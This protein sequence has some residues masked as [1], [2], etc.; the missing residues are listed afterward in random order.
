MGN[1]QA[2]RGF[3]PG[4]RSRKIAKTILVSSLIFL[5]IVGSIGSWLPGIVNAF[6]GMFLSS[7]QS[8]TTCSPAIPN[9]TTTLTGS[10]SDCSPPTESLGTVTPNSVGASPLPDLSLPKTTLSTVANLPLSGV[11]NSSSQNLAIYTPQIRMRLLGG[12]TPHDELLG[13]G[14]SVL[15]H[16]LF[17]GVEADV[18]GLQVPLLPISSNFTITGT[19]ETGTFIL[20]RMQVT[21]GLYSGVLAVVYKATSDGPLAWDL[22]FTASSPGEYSIV[23]TWG[24]LTQTS[25][26]YPSIRQFSAHYPFG[27]YTFSWS[28]ISNSFNLTP[29]FTQRQFS[30]AID[31][32][33]VT[34][35]AKVNV[36]PSIVGSNGFENSGT[37]TVEQR[38]VFYDQKYGNWWV[39]Y[40][41][42]TKGVSYAYSHDGINWIAQK[43]MPS[44]WQSNSNPTV[45]VNGETAFLAAGQEI[46]T[47]YP[48]QSTTTTASLYYAYGTISST[49]ISWG[50][51]STQQYSETCA[52]YALCF[53]YVWLPSATWTSSGKLAFTYNA[54]WDADLGGSTPSF[55]NIY[56][57]YDTYDPIYLSTDA[58]NDGMA[59]SIAASDAYGSV[60][61]VYDT[62]TSSVSTKGLFGIWSFPKN[63][64]NVSV[65]LDC[66]PNQQD[67]LSSGIPWSF[68]LAADASFRLHLL[69]TAA[70]GGVTELAFNMKG[71][72]GHDC[73]YLSVEYNIKC[74]ENIFGGFVTYPSI[75]PDFSTSHLYAFAIYNYTSI[76]M[77]EYTGNWTQASSSFP[78]VGLSN[79]QELGSN[80]ASASMTNSSQIGL[81][82]ATGPIWFGSIP[83]QTVW[84][85][86]SSP[87]DPWNGEGIA[88]YGQYFQNLDESVSTSSGLLTIEQTDM[89]VTG[90]G[91]NLEFT[92]VYTEPYAFIKGVASVENDTWAPMGNGWQLNFPWMNN[93]KTP[94]DIH[95][96][97]GEGYAIPFE[98]WTGTNSIFD[99]HKGENFRLIRNSTATYLYT[100]SGTAYV[101]DPLSHALTKSV[102]PLGNAITF[103]YTGGQIS[104]LTD[105]IGRVFKFCYTSGLL[106]SIEQNSGTCRTGFVRR[107][108]YTY[109]GQELAS[110]ADPAGR[111]TNYTYG[112]GIS[113]VQNWIITRLTYP[114]GWYSNYTYV[115]FKTGSGAYTYRATKL[116]VAS[117]TAPVREFLYAYANGNGDQI[118]NSTVTSLDGASGTLQTISYTSY[119]F[120]FAGVSANVSDAYH[121]FL[122]GTEQRFGVNGEIPREIILVSPTQGYTNYYRYD[123]W[124]NQIYSRR[125]INPSSNWYH[126]TFNAYYNDGLPPGFN[127]FQ[128]TFS[129]SN[130][131]ATDNPWQVYN[132]TWLVNNGSYNGTSPV[133]NPAH[134]EGMFAWTNFTSPSISMIA[135]VYITK[136]TGSSDQRVGLIGHYPGSGLR[137]WALVLHNS[138]SGMKLSLLDESVTWKVENPCTL[139]YNTWYK[140][141]FTLSGSQ[142][143]GS[144]TAPGV[145]CSVSGSFASTDITTATGFGLYAGG[146]AALFANV[147]VTD[148]APGITGTAFSNSFISNG[149]PISNIHDSLAG[150]AQLTGV[151]P[152]F[153]AGWNSARQ[154][155]GSG[156]TTQSLTICNLA[157]GCKAGDTIIVNYWQCCSSGQ[158]LSSVTDTEGNAYSHIV[159]AS[160]ANPNNVMADVWGALSI[161]ADT[162]SLTVTVTYPDT[163]HYRAIFIQQYRK[164]SGFG[165]THFT[166]QSSC[167]STSESLTNTRP[168]SLVAVAFD[169]GFMTGM[170]ETSGPAAVNDFTYTNSA[171]WGLFLWDSSIPNIGSNIWTWN[172]SGCNSG[173]QSVSIELQGQNPPQETYYGYVTSGGL[174]QTK[175]LYTLT[176]GPQWLTTART[177]DSFGNLAQVVD[178]RGNYTYYTYSN[179]Y[180]NAYLTN[181]TRGL[182]PGGTKITNLY[183]YNSTTGSMLSSVDPNGYNTTYKYDVLGR[184]TRVTYP[185]QDYTI[186]AYNDA[187]NY[188]NITNENSWKTKQIYDGLGRLTSTQK[189]LSGAVYS[190]STSTYNWMDKP[191]SNTDPLGNRYSYKY[192]AL[193][194]LN[195]TI[196]PD[197]NQTLVFYNDTASWVRY[198][199]EY[200]NFRCNIYDRLGRLVSVI[201]EADGKCQT[202]IVTNYYYDEIGDLVKVTNANLVST[203]Y[204]YDSVGRL[205]RTI[206]ADSTSELYSY[207]N[208]GNMASKTDRNGVQTT[209]AY[210]SLD[211]LS[212]ITYHGSTMTS[213]SY[214]YDRDS[215]LLQLQNQ[216]ATLGYTYDSRSRV[217][218][219]TYSV[220]GGLV[221]GPCGSGGGGG[222]SVA[223]GTLITT[224]NGT[225]IAV[226]NLRVGDRMLGY[227]TTTSQFTVS[228]VTSIR[229]VDTSNMLII[230]TAAGIP[231]RVDANPRQTLWVQNSTGG[232]GWTPVTAIHP[233]DSLFTVNGWVRVTGIEF[234]P[235][236]TH[237]MYDIIATAPYFADGYL[238]PFHKGPTGSTSTPS[239]IMLGG[240]SFTYSYNGETL[241]Q[242]TY[243]DWAVASYAYD[244]LGRV[245]SVSINNAG[246]VTTLAQFSY[247]Q[248]DQ[249][250]GIVYGNGIVAN[251]TYT[252]L[253]QTSKIDVKNGAAVL[254]ELRYSYNKTGT[255]ASVAG[256]ITNTSGVSVKLKDQYHYDALNRVLYANNTVGTMKPIIRYTYDS[257]GNRLT[258]SLN[259]V[260]TSYTYD[261]STNELKSAST[262]NG[263]SIGYSYYPNGNL[264]TSNVTVGST[265]NRWS[266]SWSVPGSRLSVTN[267]TLVEGYYA[268]D[269]LERMVEANEGSSTTFHSYT[270]TDTLS[271]QFTSGASNDYVYA[272]G[273]RI[274]RS[275]EYVSTFYYHTDALGSTRLTTDVSHNIVFSDSYQAYGQDNSS[276]GSETYKFTGKPASQTTGLYYEYQRWYDP[277]IGRFISED[278]FAAHLSDPQSLNPYVYSG[279]TPTTLT[280]PSGMSDSGGFLG[281]FDTY[282]SRPYLSWFNQN[283]L[284]P[285]LTFETGGNQAAVEAA[286]NQNAG[287]ENTLFDSG[288]VAGAVV[289]TAAIVAPFVVGTTA[290]EGLVTTGV[291]GCTIEEGACQAGADALAK[292]LVDLGSTSATTEDLVS[293]SRFWSTTERVGFDFGDSQIHHLLPRQFGAF[294]ERAG[295][296]N[297]DDYTVQ[298]DRGVHMVLHGR[299]GLYAESWNPAWRLFLLNNPNADSAQILYYLKTLLGGF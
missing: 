27:D 235:A 120:S 1:D 44:G 15:S 95:L 99:N 89:S 293:T 139:N 18:N 282:V 295:I 249:T 152:F 211:R 75:T 115:P 195:T 74:S 264:K 24:N 6:G 106:T 59:T 284:V 50:A 174:S 240:Y 246:V 169:I 263:P 78:V 93:T 187:A 273:L 97:N 238:D 48:S 159:L 73:Q 13:P 69:Y 175:R 127:V 131:T 36:D 297:I 270:G 114:T 52:A 171:G 119:S 163:S 262:T 56:L 192:D 105:T 280:D 2:I 118:S 88:P 116:Y 248:N 181:E 66:Y 29:S 237:V 109:N 85:P 243:N 180:S 288:V 202:G 158:S 101:F 164:V 247:T 241:S 206:Y 149:A 38:H 157:G 41:N 286:V 130:H 184:P 19:N 84:S 257:L 200:Q 279:N 172:V 194:R 290:A 128:E 258:Q 236:G 252:K 296:E 253:G 21:A 63:G 80:V 133:F 17:W 25:N 219:E 8:Q 58:N 210:D 151:F 138:T 242:I 43:A 191:T 77:K 20:R 205:L 22:Q 267:N 71:M 125:V 26:L 265:T 10:S 294:F 60:T 179:K 298:L 220:N 111:M 82:W 160:G 196:E 224:Q 121:S 124:G 150:S 232:M 61:I 108:V 268:Y 142:A 209:Y 103:S 227:N 136:R 113:G 102:D 65:R 198:A 207:D 87:S 31:L 42:S 170:T 234:A 28:D 33:N 11:L 254:L 271:D 214:S 283:V 228:L 289:A 186:Y 112:L 178:S 188:V 34:T 176:G 55:S 154:N 129:Q 86:F 64:T 40:Y 47:S 189:F 122:K 244:G 70:Y 96:W 193:G 123:L 291:S 54:M 100:S 213:D 46:V 231:F 165:A 177:Y 230:N 255:V 259:G 168:N 276:S 203:F 7:E 147:T 245:S 222:G 285:T 223:Y 104:Q 225:S 145:S 269:G 32:G 218:C 272:N 76:I 81:V 107:T 5:T 250:K 110:V 215:N 201:E 185:T 94:T 229:V 57:K 4:Y 287:L 62:S 166:G 167:T 199:D 261:S 266:Y 53:L 274:A 9:S 226:Q 281:A 183:G 45:A 153:I 148:V 182:N 251:Y 35:G 79:P 156:S 221:D 143:W 260:S 135:S 256:N 212:T 278:P 12:P 277:S 98:F 91:L 3:Y 190:T 134:Q 162:S 275:G 216:N 72:C 217:T 233:G 16:W 23:G 67:C 92:R 292:D 83:I 299:G 132:G 144:A 37:S 39:F 140:F 208:N 239:G 30:L 161:K 14:S 141:N 146:Y 90:R 204:T 137:K 155:S 49:G 51:A 173:Y 126:E 68:S 117:S 197:G